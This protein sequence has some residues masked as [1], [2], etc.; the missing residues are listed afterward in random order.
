[1]SR[2]DRR[3]FSVDLTI[4]ECMTVGYYLEQGIE[5]EREMLVTLSSFL[6]MGIND[7]C[8]THKARQSTRRNIKKL[9]KVLDRLEDAKIRR[10]K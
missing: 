8:Y 6:K 3:D 9:T 10:F 1:M 2:E 4:E 5:K 7:E